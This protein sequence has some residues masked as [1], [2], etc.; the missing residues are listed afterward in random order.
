MRASKRQRQKKAVRERGKKTEASSKNPYELVYN[1]STEINS[2]QA[3]VKSGFEIQ[4][5]R[6]SYPRW[7]L[8]SLI[9]IPRPWKEIKL[10][11][12]SS[13]NKAGFQK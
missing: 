13:I 7:N 2:R 3:A 6:S 8:I 11:H 12:N 10:K 1:N 4:L 5:G 9:M